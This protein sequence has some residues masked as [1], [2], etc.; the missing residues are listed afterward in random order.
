LASLP[1]PFPGLVIR[2]SYLW[3]EEH[4]RG[5]EEGIKDRPCAIVLTALV[6]SERIVVTVVP[7]THSAPRHPRTA[8]ELPSTTKRRLGLDNE[9]SWIVL[10]EANR[11]VWPGPDIRPVTSG[12]ASTIAYGPLP[13]HVFEA[14]RLKFLD[15]VKRHR[16][17]TIFRTE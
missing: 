6:Q 7:V 16:A 11:F 10:D 8:L 17:S 2:Y 9:R 4:R 15:N 3:L 5:R 1:E 12:D 14:V 13:Y